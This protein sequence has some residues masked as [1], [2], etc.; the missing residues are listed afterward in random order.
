[1]GRVELRRCR[2]LAVLGDVEAEEPDAGNLR[3]GDVAREAPVAHQL[4]NRPALERLL[5]AA[6]GVALRGSGL[7]PPVRV[8]SLTV[9][10]STPGPGSSSSDGSSNESCLTSPSSFSRCSVTRVQPN[11]QSVRA[12]ATPS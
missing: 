12:T 10:S 2:L 3:L 6:H 4:E 5:L 7:G 1:R 8:G 9:S 11:S